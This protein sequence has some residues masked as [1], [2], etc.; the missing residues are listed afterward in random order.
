MDVFGEIDAE[1]L[2]AELE[3]EQ[4]FIFDGLGDGWGENSGYIPEAQ[5]AALDG[6]SNFDEFSAMNSFSSLVTPHDS[7]GALDGEAAFNGALAEWL[8]AFVAADDAAIV[9]AKDDLALMDEIIVTGTKTTDIWTTTISLEQARAMFGDVDYSQYMQLAT[10]EGIPGDDNGIDEIIVTAI[11]VTVVQHD[12]I[13][14]TLPP[15]FAVWSQPGFHNVDG[16]ILNATT[17]EVRLS[18]W[19]EAA[20]NNIEIDWSGVVADLIVIATASVLAVNPLYWQA[21]LG[22]IGFGAA[23]S[24]VLPVPNDG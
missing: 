17:G 22:T 24:T 15:G 20:A 11:I 9:D 12:G 3:A 5:I 23:A 21:L 4:S 7:V 6:E 13:T 2:A 14:Y 1:M 8:E 16:Y 10:S 18:P 19:W